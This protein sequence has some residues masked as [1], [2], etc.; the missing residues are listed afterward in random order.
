MSKIRETRCPIQKSQSENASIT[1]TKSQTPKWKLYKGGS[2]PAVNEED[3]RKFKFIFRL[4]LMDKSYMWRYV[5]VN[6]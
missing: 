5:N 2:W 6:V 1:R 4:I 3:L